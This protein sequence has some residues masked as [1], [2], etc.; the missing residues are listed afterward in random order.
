MATHSSILAWKFHRQKNLAGIVHGVI[1][2]RTQLRDRACTHNR[3]TDFNNQ[4]AWGR[5]LNMTE[6]HF[7]LSYEH[8]KLDKCPNVTVPFSEVVSKI[9]E[10]VLWDKL[11]TSF[12][13]SFKLKR[14]LQRAENYLRKGIVGKV[15]DKDLL[16]RA[17]KRRGWLLGWRQGKGQSIYKDIQKDT[18]RMLWNQERNLLQRATDGHVKT[19]KGEDP[20]QSDVRR[21]K[22][23][24]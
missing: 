3:L 5:F 23:R 12:K 24:S 1:K 7:P 21:K 13:V 22:Q 8:L 9:D 6:Q 20:F 18:E 15:L 2:S 19:I 11:R 16:A 10:G 14:D 17:R 4:K